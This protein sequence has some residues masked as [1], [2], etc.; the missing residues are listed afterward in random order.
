MS[1]NYNKV[2]HIDTSLGIIGDAPL[3]ARGYVQYTSDLTTL[4]NDSPY[5]AY[6][7]MEVIVGTSGASTKYRYTNSSY[8]NSWD[9]SNWMKVDIA[10]AMTE[11]KGGTTSQPLRSTGPIVDDDSVMT[12]GKYRDD[13]V[14]EGYGAPYNVRKEFDTDAE[15]HGFGMSSKMLVFYSGTAAKVY[16]HNLI[17]NKKY[18]YNILL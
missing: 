4:F 8:S 14:I 17:T 10:D 1:T 2:T 18:V 7:G 15:I 11:S 12:H 16:I 3:D 9:I 5:R 6:Y 13:V